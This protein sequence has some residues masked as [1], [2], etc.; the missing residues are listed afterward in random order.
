MGIRIRPFQEDI[1]GTGS[2]HFYQGFGLVNQECVVHGR[3]TPKQPKSSLACACAAFVPATTHPH[4]SQESFVLFLLRHSHPIQA[5][6]VLDQ[7]AQVQQVCI[8]VFGILV[9]HHFVNIFL[10][11]LQGCFP[12]RI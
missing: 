10:L 9:R 12:C 8:I 3:E 2:Q 7:R 5:S 6:Q 1:V 4:P 11:G